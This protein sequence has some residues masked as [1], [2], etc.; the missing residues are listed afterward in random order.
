M[1]LLQWLKCI[2]ITYTAISDANGLAVELGCVGIGGMTTTRPWLPFQP[3]K[4][5]IM[6][7]GHALIKQNKSLIQLRI[8]FRIMA[9]TVLFVC[10]FL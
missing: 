8:L 9:R 7:Q 1:P 3:V 5:V 4:V 10:L 6:P 2:A